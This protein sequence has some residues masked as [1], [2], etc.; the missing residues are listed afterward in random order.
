MDDVADSTDWLNTPLSGL[1]PL[2]SGLRCQVCKDFFTTP[3]ITSCSHTFCSLCIRRYLSQEGKCPACRE[4]DQEMKLRRNWAIEELVAHFT[5]SR[6]QILAFARRPPPRQSAHDAERPKK[7]RKIES[8]SN[9]AERRSTRSQSKR[10]ATSASQVSQDPV[11]TQEEV[12][13]SEDEGSVYQDGKDSKLEAQHTSQRLGQDQLQPDDGLVACPCCSKRMKETAINAHLDRCV[14]GISTSPTPPP[15]PVI[16]TNSASLA[17]AQRT[18]SPVV[19]A[20]KDRLPSINYALYSDASLRK[21]LKELGIPNH[22]SKELMRKR[23]TEWVNLW[24]ANCDSSHPRTKR[25]LLKDLDTWER[26]LG[27]QLE[28]GT[29]NGSSGV[30]VKDFDRDGWAK[31]QK[32]D[33]DDLIKKARAKKKAAATLTV[34]EHQSRPVTDGDA[35]MTDILTEDDNSIVDQTRQIHQAD[36]SNQPLA[37]DRVATSPSKDLDTA[38]SN[39]ASSSQIKERA[40]LP[41]STNG[42]PK[43]P[44]TA[45]ITKAQAAID[46]TTS[47]DRSMTK[48]RDMDNGDDLLLSEQQITPGKHSKFFV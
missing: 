26:T 36:P 8:A 47:P 21:K 6:D 18:K 37:I 10:L 44:Q 41:P 23:H 39:V 22:G 11:S 46:L 14:Q 12:L 4:S 35:N 38:G 42:F 3:M 15:A 31:S 9:S 20:Q 5:Q 43:M 24:N 2:E 45:P 28:R 1:A 17:F 27:R 7:R 16:T 29:A 48:S 19:T 13:D 32:D 25:D 34:G 30:M 40:E 33:F